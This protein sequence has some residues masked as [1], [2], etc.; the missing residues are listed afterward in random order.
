[1]PARSVL[2]QIQA[3]PGAQYQRAR[4]HRHGDIGARQNTAYMR[5]HV[6]SS[7][8]TVLEQEI[9]IDYKTAH[10]SLKVAQNDWICIFSHDQRR[11]RM[12]QKNRA[13][14]SPN[15]TLSDER[16]DFRSEFGE[17]TTAT[18]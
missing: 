9:T 10:E 12:P 1:M 14:T 3:L 4:A 2:P 17:A 11:A 7:L 18:R 8:C 5:W 13:Q 15:A 6:V 16:L